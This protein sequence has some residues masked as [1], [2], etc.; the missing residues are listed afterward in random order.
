[1]EKEADLNGTI[2][3]DV[4]RQ[5]SKNPLLNCVGTHYQLLVAHLTGFCDVNSSKPG[6]NLLISGPVT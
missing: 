2:R 4:Y 3:S 5:I 6:V 1:M